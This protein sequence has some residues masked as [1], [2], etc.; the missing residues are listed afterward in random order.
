MKTDQQADSST[1]NAILALLTEGEVAFVRAATDL[2]AGEE[3]IDLEE[4]AKGVQTAFGNIARPAGG[5]LPKNAIH[6]N[7]WR[8]I[9]LLLVVDDPSTAQNPTARHA[10]PY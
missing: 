9:T 5:L 2:P 3:Y 1:R 4:P 6:E 8:K 10:G 7:T